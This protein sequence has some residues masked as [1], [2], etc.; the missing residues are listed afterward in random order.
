MVF[1][2]W[3]DDHDNGMIYF[4]LFILHL[5]SWFQ[6]WMQFMNMNSQYYTYYY[7]YI[8]SRKG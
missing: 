4:Y 1:I 6:K 2:N 7:P 3:F 5:Y 8:P